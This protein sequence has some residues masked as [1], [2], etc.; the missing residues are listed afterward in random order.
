MPTIPG[1]PHQR[2]AHA[3][4]SIAELVDPHVVDGTQ[5]DAWMAMHLLQAIGAIAGQMYDLAA[6]LADKAQVDPS[7]RVEP[8]WPQPIPTARQLRKALAVVEE[9]PAPA[10]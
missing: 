8:E 5:P 3:Q 10:V 1:L 2:K 7:Q 9:L 4:Q 6:V